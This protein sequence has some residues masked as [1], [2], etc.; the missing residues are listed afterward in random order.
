MRKIYSAAFDLGAPPAVPLLGEVVTRVRAWLEDQEG[1]PDRLIAPPIT[2]DFFGTGI[3]SDEGREVETLSWGDGAMGGWALRWSQPPTESGDPGITSEVI[4][5]NRPSRL[6]FSI[7]IRYHRN[8][9]GAR[10]ASP[11]R[12]RLILDLIRTYGAIAGLP[13]EAASHLVSS[14]NIQGFIEILASENRKLP[15]A[16]LSP[17]PHSGVPACDPELVA[18]I[19]AGLAHVYAL[20]DVDTTFALTDEVGKQHS[21]YNGCVRL[22]WPGWSPS[23][24]PYRHRLFWPEDLEPESNDRPYR[25]PNAILR[26]LAAA[27]VSVPHERPQSFLEVRLES[28]QVEHQELLELYQLELDEKTSEVEE[29]AA[30]AETLGSKSAILER[31]IAD[32]ESEVAALQAQ[33]TP[34]VT[35]A[36]CMGSAAKSGRENAWER[37]F[38]RL[39]QEAGVVFEVAYFRD[40]SMPGEKQKFDWWVLDEKTTKGHKEHGKGFADTARERGAQWLS[41]RNTSQLS[42]APPLLVRS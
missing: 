31:T 2:H 35:V 14:G 23:D 40:G 26:V 10:G 36:V 32:L 1:R 22:Y 18:N 16:L 20:E 37:R 5:R 39:S 8:V 42:L 21:C 27:A 3:S 7:H 12:P 9:P 29:L 34:T 25:G 33:P 19:V 24:D 11:K 15:V 13:V 6:A 17:E 38:E 4:L 41:L 28:A 30:N